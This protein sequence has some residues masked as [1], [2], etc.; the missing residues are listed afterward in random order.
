[1]PTAMAMS[2]NC[3]LEKFDCSF[4]LEKFDCSFSFSFSGVKPGVRNLT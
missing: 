4:S 2:V 1:M 3:R